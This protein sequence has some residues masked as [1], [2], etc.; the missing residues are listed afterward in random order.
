MTNIIDGG[1][2]NH[3]ITA[4]FTIIFVIKILLFKKYLKSVIT[5]KVT[6]LFLLGDIFDLWVANQKYFINQYAQI[7]DEIKKIKKAGIE[8]Y[9]FEGNH[10]LHLKKFW[11]GELG[12]KV[13]DAPERLSLHGVNLMLA[14]G[15][16][17]DLDDIGYI[18]LRKFFR[19]WPM[20]IVAHILPGFIVRKIGEAADKKSHGHYLRENPNKERIINLIRGYAEKE[21]AIKPYDYCL[22]GHF[23]V[24]DEHTIGEAKA[25]NLG[26]WLDKP[27]YY[28]ITAT[29]N[30]FYDL[31][32]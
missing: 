17:I 22:T 21:M 2:S 16:Q 9:Y 28:Q 31:I 11:Q 8:I 15:D 29:E 3:L 30:R 27:G 23:H 18:R 14:H 24:R 4:S 12:C 10:D 25:I 1:N 6:H 32:T 7:I 5:N 19:S 20:K 26:T 13:Y